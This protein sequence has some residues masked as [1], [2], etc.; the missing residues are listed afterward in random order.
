MLPYDIECWGPR[1]KG[2]CLTVRIKCSPDRLQWDVILLL[3]IWPDVWEL[4]ML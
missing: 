1:H 2:Y 3:I 4:P